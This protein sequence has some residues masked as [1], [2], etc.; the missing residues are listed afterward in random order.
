MFLA[1]INFDVF[2]QLVID[3]RKNILKNTELRAYFT[4]ALLVGSLSYV[5]LSSANTALGG[6]E[7]T[8]RGAFFSTV[9]ILTT[10]GYGT[11]DFD[12]WPDILRLILLLLMFMGGCT[13]STAGGMKVARMVIFVKAAFA[14]LR[15]TIA[16]KTIVVVRVGNRAI[17]QAVISNVQAFILM[18]LALMLLSTILLTALG[19]DLLSSLSGTVACL[20]NIGPGLGALGPT[21]NFAH[22][23]TIG[24]WVLIACQLVG[25]L[26]IYSVLVLLL[27]H[28]WLR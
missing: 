20:G 14:E 21:Q 26:E 5:L 25:R 13:G 2:Q 15:R 7:A 9:S 18:W 8:A 11:E 22:V 19:L 16:P 6:P 1:G 17:D 24:K 12:K 28:S 3:P 27:K 10:T 4:I 23:P